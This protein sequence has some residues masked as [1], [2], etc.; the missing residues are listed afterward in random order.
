MKTNTTY[1][2]AVLI[3]VIIIIVPFAYGFFRALPPTPPLTATSTVPVGTST[4]ATTTPVEPT[5]PSQPTT[6]VGPAPVS[7]PSISYI[8]P[9]SGKVGSTVSV[10]GS[11]FLPTNTVLFDGG[12]V[13]DVA[14][15]SSSV[16]T[17]TVPSSVGADCKPDQ[18][19]PMYERL[20]SNG[21]NTISVRNANGT[22]NSVN[23]TVTGGTMVIPN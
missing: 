17:F 22:S 21:T 23:F 2:L 8:A 1:A 11:G 12:P 4:E 3:V 6:P 10:Y 16:L 9:I 7:S 20:I 18:A 14:A 15:E 19:C 5:Q 13:N